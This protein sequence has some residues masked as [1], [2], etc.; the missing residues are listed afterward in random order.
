MI[1]R[2]LLAASLAVKRESVVTSVPF[3]VTPATV[4]PV[5]FRSRPCVTAASNLRAMLCVN[6]EHL[7]V[8]KIVTRS[9]SAVISAR[10]FATHLD[11]V[12]CPVKVS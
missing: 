1:N 6:K 5:L 10:K 2:Y 3:H 7:V 11:S 4:L 9:W 12:S 8:A